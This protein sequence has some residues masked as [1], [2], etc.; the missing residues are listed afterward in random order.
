MRD[1]GLLDISDKEALFGHASAGA[2][3]EGFVI[4]TLLSGAPPSC[5]A[6]FYRSGA[7]AEIDL[8]LARASSE[9]WAIEIKRSFDPRPRRG[10]HHACEDLQPTRHFVAYPGTERYRVSEAVEAI[11]I[12]RLAAEIAAFV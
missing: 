2:S 1:S 3:Y 10:F 8:L 4:E 7:G 12:V 9:I 11:P 5:T 6:Y